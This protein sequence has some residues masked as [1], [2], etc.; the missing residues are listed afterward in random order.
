M[1]YQSKVPGNEGEGGGGNTIYA[2]EQYLGEERSRED[3]SEL[4]N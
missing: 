4:K 1:E 3:M 2:L